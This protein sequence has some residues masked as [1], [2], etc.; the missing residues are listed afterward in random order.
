MKVQG[1]TDLKTVS[2]HWMVRGSNLF[3]VWGLGFGIRVWGSRFRVSAFGLRVEGG[4]LEDDVA[5][6][7][8]EGREARRHRRH[9]RHP[10]SVR[11]GVC[12]DAGLLGLVCSI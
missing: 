1:E 3:G 6:L 4:G 5:A 9:Q 12:A 2:P 7:D 8:R 10:R 11:E